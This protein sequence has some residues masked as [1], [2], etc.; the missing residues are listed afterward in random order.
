M[1]GRALEVTCE[2]F[3]CLDVGV[4]CSLSVITTLE[5]LEHHFAK[6]GHRSSPYDPTLSRQHHYC[7]QPT[8]ESVRREA[9]SFKRACGKLLPISVRRAFARQDAKEQAESDVGSTVG[10]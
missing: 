3:D 8:R 4:Y 2:V 6:V 10:C 1:V 5:F 7:W 9:A